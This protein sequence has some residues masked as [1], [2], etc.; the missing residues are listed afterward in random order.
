M[1]MFNPSFFSFPIFS[2]QSQTL[3]AYGKNK[4]FSF[5][6]KVKSQLAIF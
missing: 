3:T 4:L 2:L 1:R 6:Q 5:W